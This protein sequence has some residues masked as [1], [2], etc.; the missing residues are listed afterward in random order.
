MQKKVK[1][2]EKSNMFNWSQTEHRGKTARRAYKT[3]QEEGA[4]AQY[5]YSVIWESFYACVH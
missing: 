4:S 1:K 3:K 2:K 5:K